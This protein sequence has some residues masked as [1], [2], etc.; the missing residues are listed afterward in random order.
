MICKNCGAEI[1]S[2]KVR[3]VSGE[4]SCEKCG[5]LMLHAK[6]E[7]CVM[8]SMETWARLVGFTIT[9]LQ[10]E[11][12]GVKH[13]SLKRIAGILGVDGAVENFN[14]HEEKTQS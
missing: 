1:N 13:D 3:L 11:S 5:P 10:A 7:T 2:M 9:G 4:E 8:V 12:S 14:R 6:K